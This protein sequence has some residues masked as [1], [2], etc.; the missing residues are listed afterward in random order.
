MS[1]VAL[2]PGPAGNVP[3]G[4]AFSAGGGVVTI[5]RVQENVVSAVALNGAAAAPAVPEKLVCMVS[6]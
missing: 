6:R 5:G 2:H 1:L 3:L 4:P